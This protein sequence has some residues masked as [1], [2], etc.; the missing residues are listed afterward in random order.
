MKNF[1]RGLGLAVFMAGAAMPA[2]GYD[3]P[4][5]EHVGVHG[6]ALGSDES[7]AVRASRYVLS[8]ERLSASFLVENYGKTPVTS[9]VHFQFKPVIVWH[10]DNAPAFGPLDGPDLLA[11]EATAGDVPLS[12]Q[13]H[14]S[15]LFRGME[16]SDDLAAA[17]LGLLPFRTGVSGGDAEK[18][19]TL[20]E[21][22]ILARF[23]P[24]WALNVTRSWPVSFQPGEI[25]E[26]RAEAKPILGEY[27]EGLTVFP[28]DPAKLQLGIEGPPVSSLCL[29][30]EQEE[31][32]LALFRA[33]GGDRPAWPYTIRDYSL[34]LVSPAVGFTG[35]YGMEFRIEPGKPGDIVAVC[36][37][38][39]EEQADGSMVWKTDRTDP[40]EVR[41][42]FVEI[43]PQYRS[44]ATG[45]RE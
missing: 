27:V 36:G 4:V 41:I 42:H 40:Q 6:L 24:Q 10:S 45:G 17:G 39:F 11:V 37:G 12:G 38:A 5:Y 14:T 16:V 2:A 26:F 9:H 30:D 20:R 19:A 18:L 7:L 1:A 23:G 8:P 13:L 34:T 31:R 28:H 35:I 33:I 22:G 44:L 21:R 15:A 32:V 43:E 3:G 25:T 29:S